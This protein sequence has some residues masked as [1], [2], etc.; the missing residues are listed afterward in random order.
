MLCLLADNDVGQS[1]ITALGREAIDE[2]DGEGE[3][4]DELTDHA[5]R[6]QA[7]QRRAYRMSEAFRESV[8]DNTEVPASSPRSA[9][10]RF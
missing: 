2:P 3:D 4:N 7:S 10:Q 1:R 6:L 5:A 9:T 8:R